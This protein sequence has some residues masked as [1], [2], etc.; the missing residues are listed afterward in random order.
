MCQREEISLYI[1][2]RWSYLYHYRISLFLV[3]I[4]VVLLIGLS[5]GNLLSFFL[6]CVLHR[7]IIVLHRDIIW[8]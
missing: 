2:G 3:L 5:F 7:D 1:G 6:N 8:S 4:F